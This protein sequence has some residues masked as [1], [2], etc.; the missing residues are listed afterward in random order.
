MKKLLLLPILLALTPMPSF[1]RDY[2]VTFDADLACQEI[3]GLEQFTEESE[4]SYFT[5]LRVFA[6]FNTKY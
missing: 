5:C 2:T 3:V 1:A 6:Y 4:E